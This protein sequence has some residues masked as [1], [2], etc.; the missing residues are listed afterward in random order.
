[1][2]TDSPV[3]RRATALASVPSQQRINTFLRDSVYARRQHVPGICDFA[4]GNPHEM[5]PSAY[6]EALADALTPRNER[7]FAYKTNEPEAQAAA[8]A[9]CSGCWGCPSSRRT[10]TS[11][12][13]ASPRFRSR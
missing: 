11:R 1:M 5:P 6:V 10:S 3:S 13:A 8:A 9:S 12:P 2:S 7:W 4:L